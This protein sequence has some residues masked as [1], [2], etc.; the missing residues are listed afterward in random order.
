MEPQK[1]YFYQRT[2]K[3]KL[4]KPTKIYYVKVRSDNGE[5][6]NPISTGQ[7]SLTAAKNWYL[8]NMDKVKATKPVAL[9]TFLEQ[10]FD[11][12]GAY[13]KDCK[14]HGKVIG[15]THR[16]SSHSRLVNYFAK[17]LKKQGI[18]KIKDINKK[19]M[20][21][22]QNSLIDEELAGKTINDIIGVTR[23][24][25]N[26]CIEEDI[27]LHDPLYGIK[28]M[29]E[30]PKQRGV[31]TEA[32]IKRF[33]AQ[34]WDEVDL[35]YRLVCLV[36][37]RT[38]MRQGELC[39]L[40]A[41]YVFPDH[42]HVAHS[43]SFYD[44]LKLPKSGFVRD[45]PIIAKLYEQIK[46]YI[47]ANEI[48]PDEF[49]FKACNQNIISE[50]HNKYVDKIITDRTD[51]N[52]VF[53][54]LRHYTNSYLLNNGINILKVQAVIGH[55]SN[56]MTAEYYHADNFVDVLALLEKQDVMQ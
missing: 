7:T 41:K 38:G 26:Y 45:A 53:H 35:D 22:F 1:E 25:F 29:D 55:Q 56:A 17:F 32:E 3:S 27:I 15:E 44:G 8:K 30:T 5:L 18:T 16:H 28:P 36:A 33:F 19:V 11:K 13:I 49:V 12:D 31:M 40:K 14:H 39:G 51:R 21:A 37:Y 43:L 42:I 46:K 6:G 54:S 20:K 48:Q 34:T 9:Y 23:Q 24:V 47:D 4:K 50:I 2:I 52:I 10:F